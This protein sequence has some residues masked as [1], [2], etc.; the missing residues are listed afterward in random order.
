[1]SIQYPLSSIQQKLHDFHEMYP[2]DPSYNQTFLYRVTGDFDLQRFKSIYEAVYQRIDIFQV[3]FAVIGNETTQQLDGNRIYDF[4]VIN[5]EAT[6]TESEFYTRTK[7]IAEAYAN[8]AIDLQN[9]PLYKVVLFHFN[10]EVNYHLI[11]SP[12]V[13]ADGYSY[14]QLIDWVD[15]YYNLPISLDEAKTLIRSEVSSNFFA[16]DEAVKPASQAFLDSLADVAS[17]ELKKMSQPRVAH[18]QTLSGR[19]LH[20]SVKKDQ[21]DRYLAENQ[22]TV[23]HYFLAMHAL[24]L[25]KVSGDNQIVIGFP[26][27]NRNKH[28]KKVFGYYANTLPLVVDFQHIETFQ[29]LLAAV[30]RLVFILL[31]NQSANLAELE[32]VEQ[33]FNHYFTFYHQEFTHHLSHCQFVRVPLERDHILSEY[34]CS[35]ENRASTYEYA[36]ECGHYFDEVDVEGIINHLIELSLANINLPISQFDFLSAQKIDQVYAQ[37]NQYQIPPATRSI[38]EEFEKVVSDCPD[39]IALVSADSQWSYQELNQRANQ[40]ARVLAKHCPSD[41][42]ILSLNKNNDML[43]VILA[44]LKLGVCYIPIDPQSPEERTKHILSDLG[45]VSVIGELDKSLLL[46]KQRQ[47]TLPDALLLAQVESTENLALSPEV[48]SAAYMIYTSGS[49]GKPKGV[50]ITQHN[51]LSL[52]QASQQQF[53]FRQDDV[54]T[55]FHSYAFDFSVWEI[56]ACLLSGAKLVL[57]DSCTARAPKALYKLLAEQKVTVLNQTPTSFKRVIAEDQIQQQ[58]LALRYVIFGGE[59]LQLSALQDWV[60]RHALS[61]IKL[62]NMY[63]ITETTVHVTYHEIQQSDLE[64]STSVIGQ[65][66][67][68]LEVFVVDQDGHILPPGLVGEILVSGDGVSGGYYNRPHLNKEKF[69]PGIKAN[70]GAYRSGDL[71]RINQNGQLEHLGRIDRQVQ[72]RGYRVEI[73]EVESAILACDLVQECIIDMVNFGDAAPKLTAYLVC[74]SHYHEKQLREHLRHALPPYMVPSLFIAVDAIPTTVNGKSDLQLLKQMVHFEERSIKGQ[75]NTEQALFGIIAR[76]TKNYHFSE[77][78]NF[79]D[80]G[81][82]SI[83]LPDIHTKVMQTFALEDMPLVDIFANPSVR[84]LASYIDAL[85]PFESNDS[86]VN[87]LNLSMAG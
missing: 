47:L 38:K 17:F 23:N 43:A 7:K 46:P 34:R 26:V 24:F 64:R 4:T 87:G 62:I 5:A 55:F 13:I 54:W 74:E 51:L 59:P 77:T 29:D 58:P 44:V 32:G 18:R 50:A 27:P 33:K 2:N 12:H 66:L 28:N 25:K 60:C 39:K 11:S 41:K 35:V 6:E 67:N 1:M 82:N 20:F 31:R 53:D 16:V 10:N 42:Y 8:T 45:A 14:S 37:I 86:N 19:H 3:N 15:Y 73:G 40:I 80:V 49:T 36:L 72:I 85:L 63:G 83:D 56:F 52:L 78:D 70:Q 48:S 65:P 75:S 22:F 9:W 57:V 69:V 30:K 71:G 21:I 81:V 76:I 61:E 84:A 68:H 79:F